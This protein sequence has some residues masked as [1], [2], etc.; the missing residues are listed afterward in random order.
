ME[1]GVAAVAAMR[2]QQVRSGREGG[3]VDIVH[4]SAVMTWDKVNME[5]ARLPKYVGLRS[6]KRCVPTMAYTMQKVKRSAI[7][8][9]SARAACNIAPSL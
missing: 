9:A 8:F 3:G 6:R 1:A 2:S 4:P 7:A 5:A